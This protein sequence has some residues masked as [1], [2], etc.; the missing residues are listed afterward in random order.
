MEDG[1]YVAYAKRNL[2]PNNKL[3]KSIK[4]EAP[5]SKS[6]GVLPYRNNISDSKQNVKS[7]TKYSMQSREKNVQDDHGR[8]LTKQ[9]QEFFKDSKVRDEKGNLK[10]LYHGTP[11]EFYRFDYS[12]IGDNGTALGKGFYLAENINSAKAYATN[13]NGKNGH[14]LEVYAN[15]TKPMSLK[16]KT[17]SR[18]N[19]KKFIEAIDKKTN[20]QFLSDYGDVEYEGYN[21]VLNTALESYDYS[22]NDVDLI[23]DVL[24][25]ASLSWEEGFRLLKDTL[26]YDGVI[27]EVKFK[28]PI[29][30]KVESDSVYVPVLPEQIKLV[31]N[32]TPTNNEDIRYSQNSN[33][34]QG[35]VDQNFQ[36]EGIGHTLSQLKT[37][38]VLNPTEIASLTREDA[39]T[40][41]NLPDVKVPKKDKKSKFTKNI[42]EKTKMLTEENRKKLSQEKDIAFYKGI[43][44]KQS[45]EEAYDRLND[46]GS[47]ET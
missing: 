2:I 1:N 3:L 23:H 45:L 11:N 40:T 26:G 18:S 27:N 4:K 8:L 32:K 13:E 12:H 36:T 37:N 17:I 15:I 35:F 31:S 29:T 41:P 10:V 25:T 34:W 28:S 39:S 24:N 33:K 19:F 47:G 9:Q 44:N 5:T 22:D 6:R 14:V 43:T 42:S 21:N 20:N 7:D 16:E 38:K 30:G 46:G